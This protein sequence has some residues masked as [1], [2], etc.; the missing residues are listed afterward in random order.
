MKTIWKFPL[1]IK[2]VQEINLPATAG[3]MTVQMQGDQP[4]LWA[5]LNQQHAFQ[6]RR[7]FIVGT[8][9]SIPETNVRYIGTFQIAGGSLIFHVFEDLS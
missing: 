7:I 4:C 8:G 5:H 3:I 1:E 6:K 9:H 2:D